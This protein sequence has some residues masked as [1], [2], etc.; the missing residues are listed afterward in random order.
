MTAYS[1]AS[2]MSYSLRPH[3]QRPASLLCCCCCFLVTSV[4]NA[5]W[6]CELQL[7]SLLCPWDSLGK[8]TRMGCHDLIHGLFLTQGL[9]PGLLHCRQII[10]APEPPGKPRPLC[11]WGF[12]GKNTGVGCHALLREIFPTQRLN[13]CLLHLLHCRLNL[14]PEAL[15]KPIT[16]ANIVNNN[17]KLTWITVPI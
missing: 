12:L 9:H 8:S 4:S 6:Y 17:N 3:G 11:P 13:P 5:V 15:R 10:F 2:V 1:A 7:A 16:I 14:Y